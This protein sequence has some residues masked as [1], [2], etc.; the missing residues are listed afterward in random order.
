VA[1]GRVGAFR[2]LGLGRLELQHDADEALGQGVVDVAG[3]ALALG[4]PAALPLGRGQLAA[5]R[6]QLLDQLPALVA[7]LDDPGDPEREQAAEHHREQAAG[8]RSGVLPQRP[9]RGQHLPPDDRDAE[10]DRRRDGPG[11]AQVAE[12]LRVQHQ[13]QREVHRVDPGQQE[14]ERQQPDQVDQDQPGPLLVDPEPPEGEVPGRHEH[15]EPGQRPALAGGRRV[16]QGQGH[17]QDEQAEQGGIP[18]PGVLVPGIDPALAAL[19]AQ[20]A[21]PLVAA[22]GCDGTRGRGRWGAPDG[23]SAGQP[24]G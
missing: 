6:L 19:L 16:E 17:G 7:L 21:A 11:Q 18:D 22:S 1:A 9:A 23:G 4:Q 8:D 3:Q 5:G 2:Q 12:D 15:A 13:Q 20:P 24:F 10:G 14:P